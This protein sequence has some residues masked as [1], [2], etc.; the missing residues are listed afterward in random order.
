MSRELLNGLVNRSSPSSDNVGDA[1]MTLLSAMMEA[2]KSIQRCFARHLV[3]GVFILYSPGNVL[4]PEPLQFVYAMV[5]LLA[6]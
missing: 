4:L 6:E 3:K 1:I 2:E 5:A